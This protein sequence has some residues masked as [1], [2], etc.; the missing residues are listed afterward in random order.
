MLHRETEARNTLGR[1]LKDSKKC[2]G[3]M[4]FETLCQILGCVCALPRLQESRTM[5][6]DHAELC[7]QETRRNTE[8][9]GP[10]QAL[11]GMI[12]FSA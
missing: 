11:L 5:L 10:C 12:R 6:L 2:T 9:N 8:A 1:G 3:W 4:C 7:S